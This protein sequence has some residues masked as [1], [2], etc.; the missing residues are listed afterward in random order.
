MNVENMIEA[1]HKKFNLKGVPSEDFNGHK[2]GIWICDDICKDETDFY[3]YAE[4][5][6]DDN[7]KLNQFLAKNGWHAEP[8]DSETIMLWNT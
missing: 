7:N 2:G 4:G 1:I 3:D 5:T 8:Y 6:M